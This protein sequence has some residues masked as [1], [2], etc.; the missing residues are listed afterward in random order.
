MTLAESGKVAV[1][2]GPLH[3][4]SHLCPSLG[5]HE[6]RNRAIAA[7]SLSGNPS[8]QNTVDPLSRDGPVAT[9][10][11]EHLRLNST[12]GQI[13]MSSLEL[14]AQRQVLDWKEESQDHPGNRGQRRWYSLQ[15]FEPAEGKRTHSLKLLGGRGMEK[16]SKGLVAATLERSSFKFEQSQRDGGDGRVNFSGLRRWTKCRRS[17]HAGWKPSRHCAHKYPRNKVAKLIG[18][19]QEECGVNSWPPMTAST[20]REVIRLL[21]ISFGRPEIDL[22]GAIGSGMSFLDNVDKRDGIALPLQVDACRPDLLPKSPL[23]HACSV[24]DAPVYFEPVRE[25]WHNR[26]V[27]TSRVSRRGE[28]DTKELLLG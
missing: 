6:S 23:R 19:S 17:N 5:R 2:E 1:M 11:K 10:T 25:G 27:L 28:S 9:R 16:L 20:Y 3:K 26:I 22:R 7:E 15:S 8:Y 18:T 4:Q 24:C 21:S 14:S 13:G 12:A